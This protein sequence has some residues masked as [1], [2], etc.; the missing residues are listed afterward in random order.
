MQDANLAAK[1]DG[2]DNDR[3]RK[4]TIPCRNFQLWTDISAKELL[5]ILQTSLYNPVS[6]TL[7]ERGIKTSNT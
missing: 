1:T 6:G 3:P 4:L 7:L 2:N 5:E